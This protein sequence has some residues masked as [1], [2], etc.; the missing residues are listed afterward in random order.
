M[1]LKESGPAK[2]LPL[3]ALTCMVVVP[4]ALGSPVSNPAA[5][6]EAHPGKPVALHVIGVEPLAV[7]W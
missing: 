1:R 4:G 2:P 6:S 5:L 7:N 3:A